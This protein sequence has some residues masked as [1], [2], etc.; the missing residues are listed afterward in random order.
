VR[1]LG[2]TVGPAIVVTAALFALGHFVVD[3]RP[4]RL[5]V[6]FPAI[7]FGWIKERTGTISAPILFHALSNVFMATLEKSYFG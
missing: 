7:L 6:F 3:F 1:F 5:G 4:M 2:A